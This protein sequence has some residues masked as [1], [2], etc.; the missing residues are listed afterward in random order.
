MKTIAVVSQKGGVGKTTAVIQ[1]GFAAH[2]AGLV[3]VIIDL[4]PQGTAAKWGGRRDGDG[5]C[6]LGD[7]ASRLAVILETAR[8]HG[9][10]LCIIDT[11]PSAEDIALQA[12]MI[13]DFVLIPTRPSGLDVE[14]IQ[15]TLEMAENLGRPGAVLVNSVPTNRRHLVS[16][17]LDRLGR[18]GFAVAPVLWMERAAFADLGA[19]AM[20][21][22]ERDAESKASDEVAGLFT[23]LCEEVGLGPA[24]RA[25]KRSGP[26]FSRISQAAVLKV[27]LAA[28]TLRHH[29][30]D[31][32]AEISLG[33]RQ[34]DRERCRRGLRSSTRS[35]PASGSRK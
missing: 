20:L 32:A 35:L 30:D 6:V 1:I 21:A 33:F 8:A 9:A 24:L 28:L 19:D 27:H 26:K 31:L 15:T 29:A 3:T 16:T 10:D 13:S 2:Q 18:R 34:F 4:D 25:A 5:P 11:P 14:A 22:Q 23:W 7:Q 17:T 12:A